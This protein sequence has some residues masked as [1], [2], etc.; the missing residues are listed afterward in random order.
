MTRYVLRQLASFVPVLFVIITLTFFLVRLAPGGPFSSEKALSAEALAQINAHYNLDAPLWRQ[1]VDY[2]AGLAR[3]DLGPSMKQPSR[4]VSE[5]IAYK[6][7]ASLEL[8][9]YGLLFALCVGLPAGILAAWRPNT[10][11]AFPTAIFRSRLAMSIRA[12]SMRSKII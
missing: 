12:I 5:W 4:S 2:L 9:L 6:F 7:P 10:W 1:Y 8:G 11:I 3:G